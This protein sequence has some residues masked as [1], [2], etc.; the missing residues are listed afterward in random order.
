LSSIAPS[1]TGSAADHKSDGEKEEEQRVGDGESGG[2]KR[3]GFGAQFGLRAV[4]S[5]DHSEK[6]DE[7]EII[8]DHDDYHAGDDTM[9]EEDE[10]PLAAMRRRMNQQ[11]EEGFEEY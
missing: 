1:T 5:A 9:L 4:L 11:E 7:T 2:L 6:G 10:D 3:H 8:E